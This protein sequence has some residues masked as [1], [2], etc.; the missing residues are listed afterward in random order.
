MTSSD[1]SI[2][3]ELVLDHGN[4][5]W[6]QQDKWG[7]IAMRSICF[8]TRSALPSTNRGLQ[9]GLKGDRLAG[10]SLSFGI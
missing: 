8:G 4:L 7:L 10:G 3:S 2:E 9:R 5:G 6:T 1:S